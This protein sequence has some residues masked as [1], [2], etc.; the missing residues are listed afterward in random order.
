[1][2]FAAGVAE[3]NTVKH[4][5]VNTSPNTPNIVF[6]QTKTDCVKLP[7]GVDAAMKA[8]AGL[9]D[10]VLQRL[11]WVKARRKCG[12]VQEPADWNVPGG[13]EFAKY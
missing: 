13:V 5:H 1:M 10:K 7:S 11:A 9:G 3:S 8:N 2:V 6:D 12:G 4:K